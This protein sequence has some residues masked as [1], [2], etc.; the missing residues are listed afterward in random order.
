[1]IADNGFTIGAEIGCATGA[2][3]F[4]LLK[5]RP[6]LKLFAV[7]KWEAIDGGAEAGAMG[8]VYGKAGCEGWDHVRGLKR[9]KQV[10]SPY[11]DRMTVLRGDSVKMAEEVKDNSLDFVFIDA[12]HRYSA[13]I[14]DLAAWIP[15]VKEKGIVCGHDIHLPGVGKAVKEK[16]P[17]FRV[18]GMDHV[19]F[20]KKEDI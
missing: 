8:A 13:V 7:D 17:N 1:M 2:T 16:V 12:D 10:T 18:A 5:Y 15:K 11:R 20:C 14:G 3:T 19:W 9:F 4:R 6:D